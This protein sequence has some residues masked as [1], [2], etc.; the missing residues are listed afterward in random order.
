MPLNRRV[1][2]HIIGQGYLYDI[3]EN[4]LEAIDKIKKRVIRSDT[5]GYS[6]AFIG[7]NQ[8]HQ[9]HQGRAAYHHS[10]HSYFRLCIPGR[11]GLFPYPLAFN[12]FIAKPVKPKLLL[13]TIGN[14]I[15]NKSLSDE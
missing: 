10:H 6:D 8:C 15:E 7:W 1:F 5:D 3:A 12:D 13:E 4:G 14:N 9:D 2:E 11:S